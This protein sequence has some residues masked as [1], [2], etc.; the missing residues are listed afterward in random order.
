MLCADRW[1]F[2]GS[3]FCSLGVHPL[4]SSFEIHGL[5]ITEKDGPS[6]LPAS[7]LIALSPLYLPAVL[8][9]SI[10]NLELISLKGLSPCWNWFVLQG[11]TQKG[12]VKVRELR[13]NG[14]PARQ[15]DG[16]AD[17]LLIT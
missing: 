4:K 5:G 8:T 10:S 14:Q 1:F 13:A 7:P 6:H 16:Q 12:Q 15:R 2:E 3:S 11:G 17:G 9:A